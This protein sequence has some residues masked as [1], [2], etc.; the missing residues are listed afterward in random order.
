MATLGKK[1]DRTGL[2]PPPPLLLFQELGARSYVQDDGKLL[3]VVI[4]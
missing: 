3:E 4:E 2:G 1:N